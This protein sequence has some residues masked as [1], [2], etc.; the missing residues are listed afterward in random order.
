MTNVYFHFIVTS[1]NAITI[2]FARKHALIKGRLSIQLVGHWVYACSFMC[3][4]CPIS[5]WVQF[6]GVSGF[7]AFSSG[8]FFMDGF[9]P[10]WRVFQVT[11]G[12]VIVE[13]L[14]A[15]AYHSRP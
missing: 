1:K 9:F 6:L 11:P 5:G 2:P 15:K 3:H 10:Q 14:T 8:T 12:E 4:S 13:A 7:I